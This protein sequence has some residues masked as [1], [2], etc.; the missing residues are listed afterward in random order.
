MIRID[1]SFGE[2]GGQILRSAVALSII[3]GE[4]V[5]IDNV[6]AKR[7]VP[8]LR[9][10]H[11]TA[12]GS[13]AQICNARTEG[14]SEGSSRIVFSPQGVVPGRYHFKIGTAGSSTLVLQTVLPPLMMARGPSE[15]VIEGGTHNPLAPTVDFV[16]NTFLPL[17]AKI[18][19]EVKLV[20]EKFGFYP[21]G[22]GRIKVKIEPCNDLRQLHLNE[23]LKRT[24]V[25]ACALV[26]GLPRHIG[27][28]ELDMMK[29]LVPKISSD[30]LIVKPS[31]ESLSPGNAV[32]IEVVSDVLT[33]TFTALGKRGVP[34]EQ[35][36]EEAAMHANSYLSLGVPVYRHLADQLI[37]PLA[38]AG[39]GSFTTCALSLHTETNI[40]VVKSFLPVAVRI[41]ESEPDR[42]KVEITSR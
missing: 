20:V 34:A 18:G 31:T 14:L 1:G 39:G 28:R 23:P 35:V 33:E 12:V 9:P 29:R 32:S 4:T 40:E 15:L 38:L 7:K 24:K 10:Q 6:R 22:G 27:E 17:L 16:N 41:V 11:L 21:R 13:A 26:V 3:T 5:E 36:A 42:V 2:G 30:R 25:R 19:P 8:G 37:L